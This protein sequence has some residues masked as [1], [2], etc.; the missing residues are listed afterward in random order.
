MNNLWIFGDS[1]ASEDWN[2]SEY[3]WPAQLEKKYNVKNYAVSGTGPMHS[4]NKLYEL[5]SGA[6]REV[7]KDT[8][9]IFYM[10]SIHR[11]N[12]SFL[13]HPRDA[14]F[15]THMASNATLPVE[16]S[17]S[18]ERYK[19]YN[20]HLNFIK[21]FFKN[22]GMYNQEA[23]NMA[24]LGYMTLLK[25]AASNNVFK[26]VLVVP[27]FEPPGFPN[28]FI[29]SK[30]NFTLAKGGVLHTHDEQNIDIDLPNHMREENHNIV[31]KMTVDW[32]ENNIPFDINKL[33]KIS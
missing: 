23:L 7:L 5:I 33:K 20:K 9:L 32:L 1:Y 12:F 13:E 30:D 11:A 4:V 18:K 15:M 22:Y 29:S 17:W 2:S 27:I 21:S 24:Q 16:N 19:F 8:S 26:K 25:E 10:S 3:P 14:C 28:F 31:Y 6:N